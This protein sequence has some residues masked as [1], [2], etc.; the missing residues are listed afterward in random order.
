MCVVS[1]PI[2]P[3]LRY[4]RPVSAARI[5]R[6]ALAVVLVLIAIAI[7]LPIIPGTPGTLRAAGVSLSWWYGVLA[8]PAVATL[9]SLGALL[10]RSE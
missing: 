10:I 8:A 6:G 3:R 4:N 5:R 2:L 1:I 7:V 9:I